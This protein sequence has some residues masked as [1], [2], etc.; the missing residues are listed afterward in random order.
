MIRLSGGQLFA[1]VRGTN[2]TLPTKPGLEKNKFTRQQANELQSAWF[3]IFPSDKTS[4]VGMNKF[5]I[6]NVKC[7]CFV[8]IKNVR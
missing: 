2:V 4:L 5:A 8:D 6:G 3:L 1:H 7:S